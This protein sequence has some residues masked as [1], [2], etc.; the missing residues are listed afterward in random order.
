KV[1]RGDYGS[2]VNSVYW[3]IRNRLRL[4]NGVIV[5]RR[6]QELLTLDLTKISKLTTEHVSYME[7]H[8]FQSYIKDLKILHEKY[9]PELIQIK[10]DEISFIPNKKLKGRS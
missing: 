3:N 5:Y 2:K 8:K 7:E 6:D 1:S 4:E 10:K 9:K